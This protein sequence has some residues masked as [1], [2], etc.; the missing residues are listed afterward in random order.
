MLRRQAAGA[1][2]G[3]PQVVLG[4]DFFKWHIFK[5]TAHFMLDIDLLFTF[6]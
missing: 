4:V 6:S 3:G 5:T 2:A 1:G